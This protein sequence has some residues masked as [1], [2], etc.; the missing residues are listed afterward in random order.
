MRVVVGEG[1]RWR[2]WSLARVVFDEGCRL[3][4]HN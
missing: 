2:G 4:W 3:L 1:G